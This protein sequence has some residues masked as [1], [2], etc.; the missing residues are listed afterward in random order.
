MD[1][2]RDFWI[3]VILALIVGGIGI[4]H[5]YVGQHVWGIFGILFFWTG[6]PTIIALIQVVIWLFNG[7][8]EFN[9]NFNN[10]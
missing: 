6:I 3:A 8:D 2:R 9:K 4:H 5:F 1:Y 7:R 10:Y